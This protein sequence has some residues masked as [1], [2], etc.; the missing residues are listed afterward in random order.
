MKPMNVSVTPV[1]MVV[2]ALTSWMAITVHVSMDLKGLIARTSLV[3]H[4]FIFKFSSCFQLHTTNFHMLSSIIN[5]QCKI[6]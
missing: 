5:K 3:G 6:T 1:R 4:S 2:P